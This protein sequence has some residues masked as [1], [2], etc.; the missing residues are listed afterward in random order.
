LGDEIFNELEK[1]IDVLFAKVQNFKLEKKG[2]E[3]KIEEQKGKI[4][5]L[6]SENAS[7]KKEIEEIKNTDEIRRRKLDAAAEKIQGL[8]VKLDAVEA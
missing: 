1:K 6:E 8:L 4:G 7:L 5:E 2:L 3:Q